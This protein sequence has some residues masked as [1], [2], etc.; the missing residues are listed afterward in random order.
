MTVIAIGVVVIVIPIGAAATIDAAIR[1]HC[2]CH[3]VWAPIGGVV[4]DNDAV[5]ADAPAA[6]PLP[7]LTAATLTKTWDGTVAA[8]AMAMAATA[9]A[10]KEEECDGCNGADTCR[11]DDSLLCLPDGILLRLITATMAPRRGGGG[12]ARL[13]RGVAAAESG[14]RNNTDACNPHWHIVHWAGGLGEQQQQRHHNR[15]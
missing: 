2:H 4:V 15:G 6:L 7:P 3:H 13:R 1:T 8:T 5:V 11:L 12:V 9:M 14:D 10:T